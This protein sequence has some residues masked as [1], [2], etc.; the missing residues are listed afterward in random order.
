MYIT[1]NCIS[2]WSTNYKA[3]DIGTEHPMGL[4]MI[5][6]LKWGEKQTF[7]E[8]ILEFLDTKATTHSLKNKYLVSSPSTKSLLFINS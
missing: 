2:L 6:F 3:E 4:N 5:C 1:R 8:S 7:K